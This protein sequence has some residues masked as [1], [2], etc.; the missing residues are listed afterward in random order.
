MSA[1]RWI[2]RDVTSGERVCLLTTPHR[3]TLGRHLPPPAR[4]PSRLSWRAIRDAVLV[5]WIGAWATAG[6]YALLVAG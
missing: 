3:C 6:L 5:L 2:W 1:D 4:R